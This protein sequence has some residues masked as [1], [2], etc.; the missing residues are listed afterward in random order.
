MPLEDLV[1]TRAPL[2]GLAMFSCKN[3]CV[4]I[5]T[6][7]SILQYTPFNAISPYSHKTP[8][9][10]DLHPDHPNSHYEHRSS[11]G[12]HV[13]RTSRFALASDDAWDWYAYSLN[14]PSFAL[15]VQI[16]RGQDGP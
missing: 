7:D 15:Q 16:P 1:L 13:A 12:I 10:S 9:Y 11:R 14:S 4:I 5:I 3:V 8:Y 2:K 6:D